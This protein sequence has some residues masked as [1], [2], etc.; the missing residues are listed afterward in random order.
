MLQ[1][2]RSSEGSGADAAA[3]IAVDCGDRT[4][5][6]WKFRRSGLAI[7]LMLCQPEQASY[8]DSRIVLEGYLLGLRAG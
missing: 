1:Q 4:I 2:A 8:A 5:E 7:D 6:I 3:F